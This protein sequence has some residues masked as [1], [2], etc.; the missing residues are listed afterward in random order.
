MQRVFDNMKRDVISFKNHP[1]PDE[2]R[3][4]IAKMSGAFLL[5]FH[6]IDNAV[7]VSKV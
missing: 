7:Y 1:L 4:N 3:K 6:S 5:N 2:I